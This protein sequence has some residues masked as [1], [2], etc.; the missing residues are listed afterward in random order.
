LA[1]NFFWVNFCLVF[2]KEIQNLPLTRDCTGPE[3]PGE[4]GD[5]GGGAGRSSQQH[6]PHSTQEE[7]KRKG[8]VAL[9]QDLFIK[10]T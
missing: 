1:N 4:P 10:V 6:R 7:T 3:D 9:F 8:K 2:F 5:G